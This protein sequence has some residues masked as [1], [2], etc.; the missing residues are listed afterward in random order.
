M[1]ILNWEKEVFKVVG[2]TQPDVKQNVLELASTNITNT[3][4]V[5]LPEPTNSVDP[6]AIK[7][8]C[9]NLHIG[10]VPAFR[11]M[12]CRS[13]AA[14]FTTPEA[15]TKPEITCLTCGGTTSATRARFNEFVGELLKNPTLSSVITWATPGT[16]KKSPGVEVALTW[17]KP[18]AP[19]PNRP[20]V[21]RTGETEPLD[22]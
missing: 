11:C 7:V 6:K 16:T 18:D 5:L 22:G 2:V 8:M 21:P 15:A 12:W 19:V 1:E 17:R 13:T 9:Q 14:R 3:Y 10:Y 4:V 20:A